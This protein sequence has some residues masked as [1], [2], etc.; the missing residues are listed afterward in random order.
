MMSRA[1]PG[2][3]V[4]ARVLVV[5]D[6]ADSA[7]S[8]ARL[9]E[10]FGH[11]VQVARDGPQ[12]LEAAR[13]WRPEFVLLD[14]GM[15]GMDG[16]EVATRLRE[17][18]ACRESVLI[19]VTGYGQPEDRRRSRAVGIDH[20]LLKPVDPDGLLSLLSRS[21]RVRGDE[22]GSSGNLGP[23]AMASGPVSSRGGDRD[24]GETS[25]RPANW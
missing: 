3:R 5:E 25:G 10:L 6:N 1:H 8:M 16:Y 20:H 15:P 4:G 9:L 2:V 18:A 17:E 24:G 14:L 19:A 12:A 22:S 13:G 21:E 23:P 7:E 11:E